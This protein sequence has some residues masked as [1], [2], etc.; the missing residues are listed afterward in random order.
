MNRQDE[1]IAA[2]RVR[3]E[4]F[5]AEAAAE[6]QAKIPDGETVDTAWDSLPPRLRGMVHALLKV[7]TFDRLIGAL[8]V[9][10][11]SGEFR[12]AYLPGSEPGQYVE[13]DDLIQA[14]RASG[15]HGVEF[16]WPLPKGT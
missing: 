5:A 14:V 6:I 3:A 1:E 2:T 4:R 8:L 15:A 16:G 7:G 11:G 10:T 12:Q 9:K 13:S